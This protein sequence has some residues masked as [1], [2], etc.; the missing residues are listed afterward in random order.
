MHPNKF[1]KS[2]FGLC[3]LTKKKMCSPDLKQWL[4]NT[5]EVDFQSEIFESHGSILFLWLTS[6]MHEHVDDVLSQVDEQCGTIF[7]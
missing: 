4:S 5:M 1:L 3:K 2:K 7:P 6:I